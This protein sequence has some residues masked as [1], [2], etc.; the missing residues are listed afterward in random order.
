[1]QPDAR[2]PEH[3]PNTTWQRHRA[4][5]DYRAW[6]LPLPALTAESW[7]SFITELSGFGHSERNATDV[8]TVRGEWGFLLIPPRGF[9]EL[10]LSC[11]YGIAADTEK[12]LLNG[13]LAALQRAHPE[14]CINE[15]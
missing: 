7:A 5:T 6:I 1:M 14:I 15:Q 9:P 3:P 8:T 11:Y 13:I 4:C 10:R 12:K 2:Q